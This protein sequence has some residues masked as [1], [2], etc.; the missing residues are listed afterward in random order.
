MGLYSRDVTLTVWLYTWWHR[1]VLFAVPAE[2]IWDWK[3][4][5][6]E[7]I[8]EE[9]SLGTNHLVNFPHVHKR[10]ELVYRDGYQCK[11]N[12]FLKHFS[13]LLANFGT[14]LCQR[15]TSQ[16]NDFPLSLQ[17]LEMFTAKTVCAFYCQVFKTLVKPTEV[18]S[19]TNNIF[20]SMVK[21]HFIHLLHHCCWTICSHQLWDA[22]PFMFGQ[23]ITG[24]WFNESGS[25]GEKECLPLSTVHLTSKITV[26][27]KQI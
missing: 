4:K 27:V 1:P 12:C 6:M 18:T 9:N 11:E 15:L 21:H 17:H 25:R 24:D 20:Y 10:G 8:M 3:Q 13:L 22:D 16:L 14:L 23:S 26:T 19:N 2:G 7:Q 5:A